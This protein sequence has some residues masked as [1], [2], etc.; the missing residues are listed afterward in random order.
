VFVGRV[1]EPGLKLFRPFIPIEFAA[2][3]TKTTLTGEWYKDFTLALIATINGKSIFDQPAV[4]HPIHFLVDRVPDH[5]GMIRDKLIP[6]IFKNG[7]YY[8]H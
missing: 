4:K 7:F 5:L 2:A 3:G 8:S 1:N 6:M